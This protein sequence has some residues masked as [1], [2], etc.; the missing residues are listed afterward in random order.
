MTVAGPFEARMKI[1]RF[2]P[3][4][5]R[6]L[7]EEKV[8]GTFFL[9]PASVMKGRFQSQAAHR[10]LAPGLTSKRT[11]TLDAPPQRHQFRLG[12]RLVDMFHPFRPPR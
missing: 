12:L 5:E 8:S 4:A 7:R 9:R 1:L 2:D 10:L 3:V 11:T 6:H